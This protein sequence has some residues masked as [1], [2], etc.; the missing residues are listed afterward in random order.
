MRSFARAWREFQM[1][2]PL[3]LGTVEDDRHYRAIVDFMNSP[4]D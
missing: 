1:S 3:K 4:W 2:T